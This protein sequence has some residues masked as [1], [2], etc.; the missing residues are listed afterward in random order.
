[1]ND[2]QTIDDWKIWPPYEVFYIESLLTLTK[3]AISEYEYLDKVIT[4]QD[5]FN[6]NPDILIDLVENIINQAAT[7]S[8]YFWP[9]KQQTKIH[10]LRGEK[11]REALLINEHN[12]LKS[13]SVR[14]FVEHFDENLDEFLNKPIAGNFLPKS[15]VFNSTELNEVTFVFR[16]YIINEF[17]Y[18]TLDREICIIPIIKE[19]Y[20]IHN[21]L[22]NFNANGGRLR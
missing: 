20:R 5:L 22:V 3:T 17:K 2:E 10:R 15:I 4:S 7:I 6:Q 18:R 9:T 16:A 8:R 13:R 21:L 14:N 1:M 19:I 12:I 11:L